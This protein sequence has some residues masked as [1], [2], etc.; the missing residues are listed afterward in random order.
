MIPARICRRRRAGRGEA[1]WNSCDA[2]ATFDSLATMVLGD[3]LSKTL[4]WY[5][6]G[7]GYAQRVV[8]LVD[9]FARMEA[10]S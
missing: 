2:S 10:S 5:D 8:D 4:A 6:A 3:R 7:W 1:P 9:R